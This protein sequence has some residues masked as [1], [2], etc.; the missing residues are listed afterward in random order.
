MAAFTAMG[1]D[2]WFKPGGRDHPARTRSSTPGRRRRSPTA[3][4]TFV[5]SGRTGQDQRLRVP[6]RPAA[7][8]SPARHRHTVTGLPDGKHSFEVRAVGTGRPPRPDPGPAG[9]GRRHHRPRGDGHQPEGRRHRRVDRARRSP[10][11]SPR[12]ST[13]PASS[14]RPS[15]SSPRPPGEVVTGKVSYDPATRKAR[16]R[17]DK[18][19]LPLAAYKAMIMAG[20]KDLVGNAMPER[21][22][23]VLPDEGRHVRRRSRPP[24][25]NRAPRPGRSRARRRHRAETAGARRLLRGVSR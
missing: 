8:G 3:D 9:L 7:G 12:R 20:V 6:P 1:A 10:P 17:P 21:P 25:P 11:P 5:F 13:R 15:S 14:T 22:R 4:A 18:A 19:L 24:H 23:V 2:P 16:L